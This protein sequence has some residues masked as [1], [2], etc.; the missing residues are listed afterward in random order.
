MAIRYF[1]TAF[2][3]ISLFSCSN[4]DESITADDIAD[5]EVGEYFGKMIWN[6]ECWV[7]EKTS[8][9]KV[10]NDPLDK[11]FFIELGIAFEG[12]EESFLFSIPTGSELGEK[13]YFSSTD[14]SFTK[15]RPI[16]FYTQGD[17]GLTDFQ[18]G[19]SYDPEQNYFIIDR[20]NNDSTE[21]SGRFR[22]T[23]IRNFVPAYLETPEKIEML[24][25]QFNLQRTTTAIQW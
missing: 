18:L 3:T 16:Y 14:D 15:S 13:V 8:F 24:D 5:C 6:N 4:D 23:L 11:N 21:V 17:G 9:V 25:G 1:L 7:A 12:H 10:F 20:F 22:C 2:F 19:E